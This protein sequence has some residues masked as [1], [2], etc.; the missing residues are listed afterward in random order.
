MADIAHLDDIW[1]KFLE[2]WPVE[3]VR[4]MTLEQYHTLNDP[5]CFVRCLESMTEMLGSIWGGYAIKFG[6]YERSDKGAQKKNSSNY[7]YSDIYVWRP[8]LG[9]SPEEAFAAVKKNILGIIDAVQLKD[10]D[11]VSCEALWPMVA[12]KIAFLYQ[13][14]DDPQVLSVYRREK[15]IA[16]L[17]EDT[18]RLSTAELYRRLMAR[19]N[20]KNLHVFSEEI[21]NGKGGNAPRDG[22]NPPVDSVPCHPIPLNQILYGPPGTGKTYATVEKHWKYLPLRVCGM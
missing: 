2:L 5:T 7:I 10:L 22:Q 13:E 8:S 19:R 20:G 6:I 12:W 14:R 17:G 21:W 4:A 16:A 3:K 11:A 15:L 1:T 18:A 9:N